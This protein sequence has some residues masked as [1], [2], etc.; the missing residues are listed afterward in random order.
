LFLFA[1]MASVP[2]VRH[3]PA[4]AEAYSIA[5]SDQSAL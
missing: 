5:M 3:P 1:L 4:S 2:E